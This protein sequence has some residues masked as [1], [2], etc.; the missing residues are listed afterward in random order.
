MKSVIDCRVGLDQK[1]IRVVL[2]VAIGQLFSTDVRA[3]APLIGCGI[4]RLLLVELIGNRQ[5]L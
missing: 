3:D 4:G 5:L 2:A 1:N